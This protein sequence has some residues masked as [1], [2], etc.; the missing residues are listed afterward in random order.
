MNRDFCIGAGVLVSMLA[1]AA[2]P[3]VLLAFGLLD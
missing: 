3:W 1:A 2:T